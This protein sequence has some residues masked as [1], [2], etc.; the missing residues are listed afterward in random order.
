MPSGTEGSLT[1]PVPVAGPPPSGSWSLQSSPV[2]SHG[3]GRS[4]CLGGGLPALLLLTSN[5]WIWWEPPPPPN[6][7]PSRADACKHVLPTG[8]HRPVEI[9]AELT[10]GTCFQK[11][12][13]TSMLLLHRVLFPSLRETFSRIVKSKVKYL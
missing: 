3:C 9:S 13:G 5:L 10:M 12:T 11:I 1:E 8:A 4:R 7:H 6:N 2:S